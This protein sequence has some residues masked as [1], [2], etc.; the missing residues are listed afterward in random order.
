MADQ[1]R[2]ELLVKQMDLPTPPAVVPNV[3]LANRDDDHGD[4]SNAGFE[5]IYGGSL[6]SDQM[7]GLIIRSVPLWPADARLVL[8]GD[9]TKPHGQTLKALVAELGLTDRVAFEGWMNLDDLVARYR[10]AHLGI[11]LLTANSAQWILSVGASNKRYQYMQAG[12]PQ[13]G[14]QMPGVPE[15][16]EGNG[17]GRCL[18]E[19]DEQAIADI[20]H[21][22]HAN[23][24]KRRE[25]GRK[26]RALHLERYNYQTAFQPTLSWIRQDAPQ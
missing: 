4:H 18:V 12:L 22:Y 21:D 25:A 24:D 6:G 2:A 9:D 23:P 20:V 5:V 14:D 19:Y 10:K 1:G 8:V 15:L 17:V 26:A 16:L 13:I 3:P 11:S 7:I